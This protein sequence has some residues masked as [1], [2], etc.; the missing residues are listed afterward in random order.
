MR[1]LVN[2]FLPPWYLGFRN[3]GRTGSPLLRLCLA[4]TNTRGGGFCGRAVLLP[5]AP[6]P[7]SSRGPPAPLP[8]FALAPS[9]PLLCPVSASPPAAPSS[10][11]SRGAQLPCCWSSGP[12]DPGL[13]LCPP[14]SFLEDETPWPGNLAYRRDVLDCSTESPLRCSHP[15]PTMLPP[16]TGSGELALLADG[17]VEDA[18]GLR[19][20]EETGSLLEVVPWGC[21]T[22]I[23]TGSY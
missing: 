15:D 5:P 7:S 19:G 14:S 8:P 16:A 9:R 10:P 21:D 6:V 20:K 17:M 12:L 1:L 18:A 11:P 4:S 2:S 23:L 3:Q 22:G 13:A